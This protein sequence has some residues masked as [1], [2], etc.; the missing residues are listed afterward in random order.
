M[1]PAGAM[2]SGLF[3]DTSQFVEPQGSSRTLGRTETQSRVCLFDSDNP[4]RR[5]VSVGGRGD[6]DEGQIVLSS[7][8]S[9]FT[10]C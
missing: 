1:T 6:N 3:R 9:H 5:G 4:E 10:S 7:R 8:S 2:V